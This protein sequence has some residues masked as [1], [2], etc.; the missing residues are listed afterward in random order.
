MFRCRWLPSGR[1]HR[2]QGSDGD[3]VWWRIYL[4]FT[5]DHRSLDGADPAIFNRGR[6]AA[7]A[8]LRRSRTAD[9]HRSRGLSAALGFSFGLV[10]T[11]DEGMVD[12]SNCQCSTTVSQILTGQSTS[13][14]R[15]DAVNLS[16]VHRPGCGTYPKSCR[17]ASIATTTAT[18]RSCSDPHRVVGRPWW[19]SGA[20]QSCPS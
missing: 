16:K 18:G 9:M 13:D 14:D 11:C 8:V 5:H 2:T 12:P 20:G 3:A 7:A 6:R 4:R 1:H 15:A 19:I 10:C 17:R